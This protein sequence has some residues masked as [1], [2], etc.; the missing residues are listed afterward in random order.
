MTALYLVMFTPLECIYVSNVISLFLMLTGLYLG[1]IQIYCSK[2]IY[3]TDITKELDHIS[4]IS[5][6]INHTGILGTTRTS[7]A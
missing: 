6:N 7:S 4:L 5:I 1:Q 2:V 3:T